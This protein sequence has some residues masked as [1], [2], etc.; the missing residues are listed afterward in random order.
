MFKEYTQY[1]A[2]GLAQLIKNHQISPEEVLETAIHIIE[3]TNPNINAVITPLYD[4]AWAMLKQGDPQ[5]PFYGVP[6]LLKDLLTQMKGTRY[7]KS[8]RALAQN[9][10]DHDTTDMVRYRKAGFCVL[11]KTN[12]PEFGL[13]GVTEPDLHGPTR[14]PWNLELSPG[15]SSG[16]SAAAVA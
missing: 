2:L 10:S 9:I 3:K 12:T 11:G 8:C 1:D 4:E 13:M 14:N 15:G 16:G 6:L 5:S 7:T